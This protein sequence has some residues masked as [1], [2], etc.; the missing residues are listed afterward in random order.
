M[1]TVTHCHHHLV[2]T[3]G[4]DTEGNKIFTKLQRLF[5]AVSVNIL[6][7]TVMECFHLLN[8]DTLGRFKEDI[9][10]TDG[11]LLYMWYPY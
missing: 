6:F 5:I 2:N 11:I 1:R 9:K 4:N 7:F 10:N 8:A 3:I